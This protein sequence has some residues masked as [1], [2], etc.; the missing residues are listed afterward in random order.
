MGF[1]GILLLVLLLMGFG[2]YSCYVHVL[3]SEKMDAVDKAASLTLMG[4]VFI[5]GFGLFQIFM[6][7]HFPH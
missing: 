2:F 4:I 3:A 7:Q 1:I 5:V 6:L